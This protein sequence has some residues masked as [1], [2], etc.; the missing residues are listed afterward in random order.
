MDARKC[1]K[2]FKMRYS[3]RWRNNQMSLL[4]AIYKWSHRPISKSFNSIPFRPLSVKS[5]SAQTRDL[6]Q[7]SSDSIL[8]IRRLIKM[9]DAQRPWESMSKRYMQLQEELKVGSKILFLM[10]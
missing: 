5:E 6:L 8:E 4:K 7:S 2:S 1:M 10:E 3:L 9:I